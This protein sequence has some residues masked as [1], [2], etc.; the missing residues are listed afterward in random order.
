MILFFNQKTTVVRNTVADFR[1]YI[2]GG[3]LS[4]EQQIDSLLFAT[5]KIKQQLEDIIDSNDT[6]HL[7]NQIELKKM[8]LVS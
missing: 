3:N 5:R 7:L 2:I 8:K 1:T 6:H 4:N